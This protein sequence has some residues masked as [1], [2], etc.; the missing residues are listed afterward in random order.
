MIYDCIVTLRE[1][2]SIS[3]VDGTASLNHNTVVSNVNH[4]TLVQLD[5][6]TDDGSRWYCETSVLERNNGPRPNSPGIN[7]NNIDCDRVSPWSMLSVRYVFE[8]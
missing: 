1:F 6:Y 4:P 8:K 2:I 7:F 5:F 3:G